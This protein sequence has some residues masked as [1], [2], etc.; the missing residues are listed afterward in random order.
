MLYNFLTLENI[1]MFFFC[2]PFS[3][4]KI[5]STS[6][7]ACKDFS[8]KI[9]WK[10]MNKFSIS[11]HRNWRVLKGAKK[12]GVEA[13]QGAIIQDLLVNA[14]KF[15]I[16]FVAH[17]TWNCLTLRN[18]QFQG[19]QSERKCARRC[20]LV[21]LI[22]VEI[23]FLPWNNR[24]RRPSADKSSRICCSE[25]RIFDWYATFVQICGKNCKSFEQNQRNFKEI[26]GK[27]EPVYVAQFKLAWTCFILNKTV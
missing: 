13:L 6:F 18:L 3:P 20:L 7:Y 14:V 4:Q 26:N 17:V 5:F 12:N 23:G 10:Q 16:D 24:C 11:V 21:N 9:C 27:S 8:V 25:Q 19:N 22:S 2:F 1:F 15:D